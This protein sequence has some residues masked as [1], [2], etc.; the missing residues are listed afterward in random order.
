MDKLRFKPCAIIPVF[1]HEQK[2]AQV[3]LSLHEFA[4]PCVL[5]DDGS[6][7]ECAKVL[8]HLA[9]SYPWISLIRLQK[10][11][12][13][14]AAVCTGL[15]FAHN[16]HYTHALQVDADGQH[17]LKD[18]PL[19]LAQAQ[20]Y[21]SAVISGSRSYDDMPASRRN[22]RKLTDFLVYL[23]TLSFAIKDSMCGYRLYPLAATMALLSHRKIGA[24]MDF[25]T[26][27]IVRLY[28]QGLSVKNIPT[29]TVYHTDIPS[30]FNLILDNI[31]IT[32]MH[33][34]LLFGMLLRAP[35][36]LRH[37]PD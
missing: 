31:R 30:H 23:H 24:H 13:K 18:V 32:R 10:N 35:R 4:L 19:F 15:A 8:D 11:S 34:G 12:G 33:L 17:D 36:L 14:G 25:D 27:I 20:Q 3:L 16:H 28:W 26:D 2:I 7:A 9:Q 37:K 5:I 6:H 21:P 22:G 1:N 29:R